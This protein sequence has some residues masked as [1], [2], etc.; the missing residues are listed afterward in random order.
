MF[1]VQVVLNGLSGRIEVNGRDYDGAMPPFDHLSDAQIAAVVN[2]VPDAF[3][4]ADPATGVHAQ[5]VASARG[6]PMSPADLHAAR[7]AMR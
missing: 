3:N 4:S 2:Y 5:D 1:P 6:K 7:A